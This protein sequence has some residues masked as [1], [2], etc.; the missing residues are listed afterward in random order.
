MLQEDRTGPTVVEQTE[1][2]Y[3]FQANIMELFIDCIEKRVVPNPEAL[4]FSEFSS[5]NFLK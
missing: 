2:K 4:I 3:T 5:S 1:K